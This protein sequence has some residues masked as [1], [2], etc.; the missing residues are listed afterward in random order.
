MWEM[1]IPYGF[2]KQNKSVFFLGTHI[3]CTLSD[4]NSIISS[5]A[6]KNHIASLPYVIVTSSND[7]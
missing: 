4:Q 7:F 3:N 1:N 5:M 2:F 6:S